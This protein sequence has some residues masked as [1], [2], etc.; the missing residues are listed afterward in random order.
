[1][2]VV[3]M[4]MMMMAESRDSLLFLQGFLKKFIYY[5]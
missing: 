5:S 4:R 2:M 3:M 1:M